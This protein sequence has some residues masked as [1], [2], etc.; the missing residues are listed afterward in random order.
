MMKE[1][2]RSRVDS[3]AGIGVRHRQGVCH[4]EF[5]V[6]CAHVWG[7]MGASVWCVSGLVCIVRLRERSGIFAPVPYLGCVLF[8]SS[9]V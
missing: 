3:F 2:L 4:F 8:D 1:T 7:G 9:I 5:G 6:A